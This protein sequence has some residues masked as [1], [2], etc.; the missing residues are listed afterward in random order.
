[1]FHPER[2]L[3]FSQAVGEAAP[4]AGRSVVYGHHGHPLTAYSEDA[5]HRCLFPAGKN[6][7]HFTEKPYLALASFFNSH[8]RHASSGYTIIASS[9]A[10][11]RNGIF[12]PP[13]CGVVSKA[14]PPAFKGVNHS[15]PECK[16]KFT[17]YCFL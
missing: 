1:L 11:G 10:I 15:H 5:P 2:L 13:A 9:S 8:R 16:A 12:R 17:A 3:W 7:L 4:L 6:P 14:P